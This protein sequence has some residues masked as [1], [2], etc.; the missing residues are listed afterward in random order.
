[1][2]KKAKK[3]GETKKKNKWRKD[4]QKERI[5]RQNRHSNREMLKGRRRNHSFSL[6]QK[7]KRTATTETIQKNVFFEMTGKYV[8]GEDKEGTEKG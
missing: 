4:E 1:M 6:S 2:A 7:K 5:K 8:K 3:H